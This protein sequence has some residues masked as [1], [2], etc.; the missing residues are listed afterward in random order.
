MRETRMSG[1]YTFDAADSDLWTD[2]GRFFEAACRIEPE[3]QRRLWLDVFPSFNVAGYYAVVLSSPRAVARLVEET[4][5]YDAETAAIAARMA[6]MIHG[7]IPQEMRDSREDIERWRKDGFP[8][9]VAPH[10]AVRTFLNS[11]T[12]RSNPRLKRLAE[13]LDKWSTSFNIGADWVIDIALASMQAQLLHASKPPLIVTPI[14]RAYN[15]LQLPFTLSITTWDPTSETETQFRERVTTKFSVYL[16][17]YVSSVRT[18]VESLGARQIPRRRARARVKST[19]AGAHFEWLAKHRVQRKAP[20]TIADEDSEEGRSEVET[21]AVR[22]A[23]VNLARK[24]DFERPKKVKR[25]TR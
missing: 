7:S 16:K 17:H 10:V 3:I 19:D 6:A 24:L 12:L 1:E 25:P 13:R 14:P 5:A 23:V 15:P 2:R 4:A 21:E 11:A 8:A 18:R 20:R 22:Q 9:N